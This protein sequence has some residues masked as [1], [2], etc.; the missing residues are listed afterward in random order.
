[1]NQASTDTVCAN[2]RNDADRRHSQRRADLSLIARANAVLDKQIKLDADS[3][4]RYLDSLKKP[5]DA[6]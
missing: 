2:Q 4:R 6:V 3:A 5:K 1:M